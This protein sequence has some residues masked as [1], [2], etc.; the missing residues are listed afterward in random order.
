MAV[1]TREWQDPTYAAAMRRIDAR[2]R[3]IPYSHAITHVAGSK[4]RYWAGGHWTT[5]LDQAQRFPS[6]FSA[7]AVAEVLQDGN[8]DVELLPE[9]AIGNP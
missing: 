2:P 3:R 4:R 8:V 6:E 5:S 9:F 7:L 1:R